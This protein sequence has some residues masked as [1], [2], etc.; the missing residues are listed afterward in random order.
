MIVGPGATQCVPRAQRSELVSSSGSD[1]NCEVFIAAM[2]LQDHALGASPLARHDD[3]G[4]VATARDNRVRDFAH[5]HS[6]GAERL[7][8]HGRQLAAG[9]HAIAASGNAVLDAKPAPDDPIFVVGHWRSGTTLLHELLA[10]DTRH[11]YPDTYACLAPSHFLISRYLVPW[12]LQYLMPKKRPMDNVRVGFQQPQEDEWALCLLGL[13][14]AYRTIAFPQQL[15][16]CPDWLALTELSDQQLQEWQSK[17]E[18]FLKS[19][20]AA[21]GDRRLVLKSPT[22]TARIGHLARHFPRAKFVHVVRDPMVVFP[23]TMRLWSTLAADH[24]LQHVSETQMEHYVLDTFQQMYRAFEA[25]RKQLPAH[26]ICDV[27]Y[28]QLVADPVG[29]LRRVYEELE[30]GEFDRVLPAIQQRA[31]SMS[32][33]QTNRY[34]VPRALRQR[35]TTAWYSFCQQYGYLDQLEISHRRAG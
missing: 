1:K 10:L 15:P 7:A 35:I 29:Q 9:R 30:L 5:A 18:R 11:T 17:L 32:S 20:L 16:Q 8:G 28:E 19:V 22:H 3:F 34:H 21:R 12:W 31:Q 27:R 6:V 24:G 13:P 23:S 26:Q 25:G 2:W 14:T 33:Y 4:L